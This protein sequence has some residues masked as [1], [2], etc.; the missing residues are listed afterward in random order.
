MRMK[1]IKVYILID[2]EASPKCIGTMKRE[3]GE[4]LADLRMRLEE[5]KVL[6]FEF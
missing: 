4:S 1:I 2:E 6:K 5:N 3:D